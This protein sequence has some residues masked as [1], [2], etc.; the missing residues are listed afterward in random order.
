MLVKD[1]MQTEVITIPP[2]ATLRE[3]MAKMRRHKVKSLVV[4]RRDEHDAYGMITYSAILRTIVSEEGDID[5][6]NVYDVCTKPAL[7]VPQLM[8]VKYVAQ[9]MIAQ[10]Q[11]R[12]VVLESGELVGMVTMN[13]I[14]G[15]VLAWAEDAHLVPDV[16]AN[17]DP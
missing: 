4:E 15:E 1:I 14:V 10:F 16:P 12:V 3:T 2:L 11:R 5:L 13:D 6:I 9:M 8:D 17:N 7:I